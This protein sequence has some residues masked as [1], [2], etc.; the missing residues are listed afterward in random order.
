MVLK[1]WKDKMKMEEEAYS[2]FFFS[3]YF[4][5][6]FQFLSLLS[7]LYLSVFFLFLVGN[8]FNGSCVV[9]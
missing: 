9:C 7:F 5:F 1:S 6:V 8:G 2:V 3:S 4:D